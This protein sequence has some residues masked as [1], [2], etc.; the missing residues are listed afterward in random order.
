MVVFNL[1]LKSIIFQ[2]LFV[3]LIL[4][5]ILGTFADIVTIG[6]SAFQFCGP[7]YF[8]GLVQLI[9]ARGKTCKHNREPGRRLDGP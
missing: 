4:N 8:H 2:R 3:M 5:F 1:G 6:N 9:A 7:Q